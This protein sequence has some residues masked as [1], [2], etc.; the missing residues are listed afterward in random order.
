VAK[1]NIL[2]FCKCGQEIKVS[3]EIAR[4]FTKGLRYVCELCTSCI[5]KGLENNI[6]DIIADGDRP[7]G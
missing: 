3:P 4:K 7:K 1:D 6:G 2:F 5:E